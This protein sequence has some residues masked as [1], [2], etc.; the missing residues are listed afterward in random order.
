MHTQ[1]HTSTC[2]F[3]TGER[4]TCTKVCRAHNVPDEIKEGVEGG[5]RGLGGGA[6]A[7]PFLDGGVARVDGEHADDAYDGGHDGGAEVIYEG[8]CAHPTTRSRVQLGQ[9]WVTHRL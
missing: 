5:D 4:K 3:C 7:Q 9:T 1:T 2:T 8:P 6:S